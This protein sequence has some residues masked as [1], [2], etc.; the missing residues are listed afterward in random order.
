MQRP[1]LATSARQQVALWAISS[2]LVGCPVGAE[3]DGPEEYNPTRTGGVLSPQGTASTSAGGGTS[4]A[5]VD[6]GGAT[7]GAATTG[8]SCDTCGI[9]TVMGMGTCDGSVCHGS[10]GT[11]SDSSFVG[12]GLDLFSPT[13]ETAL[14]NQP[15]TYRDVPEADR[16]YCSDP[17]ELLIDAANPAASLIITKLYDG[18]YSCGSPM[19]LG[20]VD[21]LPTEDIQCI[22]DWVTCLANSAGE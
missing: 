12:S 17:P 20:R 9:D 14:V 3:L 1:R 15:A 7:T 18:M 4:T 8:S 21:P 5:A 11:A 10:P 6:T 22:T 19:P 13:R 16:P 2:T